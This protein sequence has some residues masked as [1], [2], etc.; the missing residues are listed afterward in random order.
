MLSRNTW[1][2]TK[3][4]HGAGTYSAIYTRH[5]TCVTAL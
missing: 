1:N 5:S 3:I 4:V 2:T